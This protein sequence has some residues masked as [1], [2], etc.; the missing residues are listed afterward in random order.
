MEKEIT[1]DKIEQYVARAIV[2]KGEQEAMDELAK[3]ESVEALKQI[4]DAAERNHR[5]GSVSPFS[6]HDHHPAVTR[7]RHLPIVLSLSVAAAIIAA[8]LFIGLQPQYS[9]DEL[10]TRWRDAVV[11]EPFIVRGGDEESESQRKSLESAIISANSGETGQAIEKL[12]PIASDRRSEYREDAQWQLVLIYLRIGERKK[13]EKIL[14]EIVEGKGS[15]SAE[16]KKLINEIN[17]KRW[18]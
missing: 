10:Y 3:V 15:L 5:P 16:A 6:D 14:C 2:R 18:F 13:A 7:K 12:I 17:M 9:T 4:L 1:D 8:V 11:Y